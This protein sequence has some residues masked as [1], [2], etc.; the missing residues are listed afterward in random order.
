MPKYRVFMLGNCSFIIDIRIGNPTGPRAVKE[1][2]F[3]ANDI[4]A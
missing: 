4:I 2:V 1:G 3:V